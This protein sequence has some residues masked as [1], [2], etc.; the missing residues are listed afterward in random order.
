M[1]IMMMYCC[2]FDLGLATK[3]IKCKRNSEYRQFCRKA[4][5]HHTSF[6]TSPTY[7]YKEMP[8]LDS[9]DK[10]SMPCHPGKQAY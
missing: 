5:L 4:V 1:H 10:T 6:I 7:S 9:I 8:T 2:C 3:S